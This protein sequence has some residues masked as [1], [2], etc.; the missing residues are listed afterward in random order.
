MSKNPTALY[1]GIAA[2]GAGGYYMYRAGGDPKVAK[3][4]MRHDA[5]LARLKAPTGDQAEKAGE[6]AA[7]ETRLNVDEA[8]DT[9]S[10]DAKDSMN[11]LEKIGR[12]TTA[13]LRSGA[14]KL[15]GKVEEKAA[16]AKGTV[17]GWFGGKK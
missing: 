5:H 6:K 10:K 7:Y 13:E 2:L 3:E 14:E 9:A 11:R 12:D 8:I 1:L 17:S 16:E 15:E 4:E